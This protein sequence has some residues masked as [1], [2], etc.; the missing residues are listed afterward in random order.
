[1]NNRSSNRQ[2]LQ[3]HL[4]YKYLNISHTHCM[5][6]P[7]NYIYDISWWLN[8]NPIGKIVKCKLKVFEFNY[9]KRTYC[10]IVCIETQIQLIH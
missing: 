9:F 7:N 3:Q 6:Y 4:R 10:N 8:F 5:V 1:M 2:M